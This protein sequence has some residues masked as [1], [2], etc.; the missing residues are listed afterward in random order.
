MAVSAILAIQ[1]TDLPVLPPISDLNTALLIVDM[2]VGL[3]HHEY[4]GGN[5]NNPDAEKNAQKILNE[6]RLAGLPIIHIQHSSTN[7]QSKLHVTHPGF[8]IKKEVQPIEGE[9]VIV[10][11][12]NSAFI[13]TD[14]HEFLAEQDITHVVVIGLT[15]NHCVS[16][17][18]RSA[19]NLG[20]QTT[21]ISDATATFDRKGIN[22]NIHDSELVHQI[23][24]AS[25]NEEFAMVKTTAQ[26]ICE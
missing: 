6:W 4:Y 21:V 9:P 20:Y 23:T 19:A 3:D 25:L 18:V 14:L 5:R 17:T 1:N 2:Q 26:I 12:V 24:L 7:P 8:A 10:K 13:G 16:S 11:T 22:G 15:T